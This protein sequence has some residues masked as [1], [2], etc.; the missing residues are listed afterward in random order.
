MLKNSFLGGRW[1][2][3][4][5]ASILTWAGVVALGAAASTV[6]EPIAFGIWALPCVLGG[7]AAAS[8]ARTGRRTWPDAAGITV[9]AV[10]SFSIEIAIVLVIGGV[11]SPGPSDPSDDSSADVVLGAIGCGCILVVLTLYALPLA[12]AGAFAAHLRAA[13]QSRSTLS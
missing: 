6:W 9:R 10:A 3:I 5:F 11:I 1:Y 12:L 7:A 8:Y 13:Q 4:G 2:A